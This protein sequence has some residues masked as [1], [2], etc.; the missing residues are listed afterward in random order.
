[1]ELPA[2]GEIFEIFGRLRPLWCP[3]GDPL[4]GTLRGGGPLG[5]GA[6]VGFYQFTP[7]LHGP[8]RRRPGFESRSDAGRS[9]NHG[10]NGTGLAL[11]IYRRISV[12]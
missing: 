6:P 9:P 7:P 1:M 12:T 8:A 4:E 2:A 5:E 10:V 3:P 11:V